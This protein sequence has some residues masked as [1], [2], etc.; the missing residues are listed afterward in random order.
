MTRAYNFGA[1]PAMLPTEVLQQVQAEL[2]DWHD[3]GMSIVEIGHRTEAF[4]ALITEVETDLRELL[5]IPE[6][7]QVLFI[8]GPARAQFAM[9]PMNLLGEAAT[10]DYL[11]TGVWSDMAAKEAQRFSAIN[12][13]NEAAQL[14]FKTIP[15][16]NTWRLNANA[17]Y[18]HY[19]VNETINGV[20]FHFIPEMGEVP[21][22]CDMTSSLLS[23]PVDISRFGIIY[24]G[25][26]KNLA[27]AGM[28]IVII[29]DDLL[30]RK[31]VHPIPSV[32]D[33]RVLHEQ[34][35][36]YYTPATFVCYVAG[37]TLKWL[38][39]Q[40]GLAAMAAINQRKAQLLYE[41]IDSSE[42]YRNEVAVACRS[43]MNVPFILSNNELNDEF[44]QQAKKA[45]LTAL[46]GHSL[47]GGMRAS[48][49]NAMPEAG[50]H[51]LID[52]MKHFAKNYG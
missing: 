8:T 21:L 24:A 51:A 28:T 15:E 40:G 3:S 44:L 25:T 41:Y 37:L 23:R 11:T 4:K 31:A 32:Y 27:P 48:L 6:N 49:Y 18:F 42:F 34:H 39:K 43:W 33:Y 5:V 10:A 36:L 46:K 16:P 47:V 30:K 7:Y 22:V 29:R 9:I 13:V 52:F 20:E 14:N 17:A 45:G 12:R 19:T 2:L 35:S 38:K 26:Q 50:V 1:G